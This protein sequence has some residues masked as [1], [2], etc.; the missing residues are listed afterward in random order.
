MPGTT[1][2]AKIDAEAADPASAGGA[3]SLD[4]RARRASLSTTRS[5]MAGPNSTCSRPARWPSG[6]LC[7]LR[8]A[9]FAIAAVLALAGDHHLVCRRRLCAWPGGSVRSGRA[10]VDV[11]LS[12]A[13]CRAAR[14][15]RSSRPEKDQMSDDRV[16]SRRVRG[17]TRPLQA[18][19]ATLDELYGQ[20]APHRLMEE[21]WEKAKDK[22]ADLAEDA[23]DAVRARPSPRPESSPPSR[24]SSPASR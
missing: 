22:G 1:T 10:F 14:L 13:H 6:K 23:V 15:A 17:R 8:R 19:S 18:A 2:S 20:F 12:A 7:A 24:C 11:D 9:L 21:V 16:I 5:I 3:G 4:Q